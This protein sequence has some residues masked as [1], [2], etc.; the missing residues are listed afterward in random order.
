MID[1]R[2][3]VWHE[4]QIASQKFK[5]SGWGFV[6]V[7]AKEMGVYNITCDGGGAAELNVQK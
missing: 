5:V 3:G 6:I 1:N 4:V 2:D 7:T